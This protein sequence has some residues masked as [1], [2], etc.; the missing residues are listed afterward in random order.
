M[1]L[2]SIQCVLAVAVDD[3]GQSMALINDI[4]TVAELMKTV[5]NDA[6][7]IIHK[8]IPRQLGMRSKL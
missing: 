1:L 8:Q 6:L 3:V 5:T 2:Q 4:P 7:D